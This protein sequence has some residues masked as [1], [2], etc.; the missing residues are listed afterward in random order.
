M[1]REGKWGGRERKGLESGGRE[2]VKQTARR[3]MCGLA[4]QRR[5]REGLPACRRC[6]ACDFGDGGSRCSRAT[7]SGSGVALGQA[8]LEFPSPASRQRWRWL[9]V[10]ECAGIGC[11]LRQNCC[12]S[13]T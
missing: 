8:E 13:L 1:R 6:W 3:Q 12:V 9:F 7:H 2:Q 11:K 5:L 4:E 10:S